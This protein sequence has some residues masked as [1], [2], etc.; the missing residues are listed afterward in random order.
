[1]CRTIL[2][3]LAWH[4]PDLAAE[5][6][7]DNPRTAWQVRPSGTLTFVPEW[8]C[9]TESSHR[10]R[11][12]T[13]V[14]VHG[15]PCPLCRES[16]K[17]L[18]ELRYFDALRNEFGE[19]FSGLSMRSDSFAR[20]SVWVPDVTVHLSDARVLLVEYDGS[21]WHADKTDVDREKSC[22]LLAAGA[23]VVRLRE[24]PLPSLGIDSRDYLELPV[25]STVPD[26]DR[27]VAAIRSWL[28]H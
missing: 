8:I 6:S 16:G 11:I 25:S 5:W 19:A 2:D 13:N 22:D 20:R 9:A 17:S 3:S 26:P 7:P 18:V 23:L 14:R 12:G 21:Y 1:V 27:A 15:S 4:Y 24:T 10:W 28:K